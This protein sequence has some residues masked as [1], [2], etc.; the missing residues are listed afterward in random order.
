MRRECMFASDL[1]INQCRWIN[2]CNSSDHQ[3]DKFG[4]LGY[5]PRGS[6]DVAVNRDIS[7]FIFILRINMGII[8]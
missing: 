4:H 5:L 6:T 8:S 3:S 7:R 2:Y 1:P